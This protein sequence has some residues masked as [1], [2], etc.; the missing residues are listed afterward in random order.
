MT[1]PLI[2]PDSIH[3]EQ[4]GKQSIQYIEEKLTVDEMI[5]A[6]SFNIMKYG[7][8]L[9][10]KGQIAS[11]LKKI[12]TYQAYKSL[13]LDMRNE[14]KCGYILVVYAYKLCGVEVSY[15]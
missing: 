10:T 11:D 12:A 15:K 3:Y 1:H 6:C 14:H 4:N 9:N 7:L 13:L 5:G 8:R 2:N